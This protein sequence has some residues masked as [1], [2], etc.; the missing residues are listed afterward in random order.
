M[1]SL[2]ALVAAANPPQLSNA[3]LVGTE[4]ISEAQINLL[5]SL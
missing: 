2:N 5:M 4:I 3:H 1:T